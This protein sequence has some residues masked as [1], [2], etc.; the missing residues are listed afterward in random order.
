MN[1]YE[2]LASLRSLGIEIWVEGQQLH[3][4]A[5][6]GVLTPA[7]RKEM[8]DRKPEILTVLHSVECS[9]QASPFGIGET[10]GERPLTLSSGQQRLWFMAQLNPFSSAYNIPFARRIKMKIV[11]E[12]LELCISEVIRRHEVLRTTFQSFEGQP[13]P[14]IHP[15]D[16][17]HL[18][19]ID[20][21]DLPVEEQEEE[22]RRLI[23]E[24]SLLPFD[25]CQGP[26]IRFSLIHL[27]PE[28]N[29]IH[30]VVHHIIFDGW[31]IEILA[32][33]IS[34]FYRSLLNNQ[35]AHLPELRHQYTDFAAWQQQQLS[36][37]ALKSQLRYWKK[38]LD[39]S[40][41][42]LELPTDRTVL[43]SKSLRGA[44]E[45][46]VLSEKLSLA[47]VT[48]AHCE[49]V[50]LFMVILA[51]FVTLLHRITGQEDIILG[52]P[53]AGRN[54]PKMEGLIGLF[55][56]TLVLRFDVSG[57]PTF[58]E[59]L[60]AVRETA[61]EA[62]SNQDVPFER[63]VEELQPERNLNHNPIFDV[64]VNFVAQVLPP[65]SGLPEL[66]YAVD[67][68]ES[69]AKFPMTLYIEHRKECF[70]LRLTYQKEIFSS[71]RIIILLDQ[72]AKLLEQ[73]VAD[74]KRKIRSFSL[75]S[76]RS[77]HLLPDPTAPLSTPNYP[78]I[79]E[80]ITTW[81]ERIP[82][83]PAV[84]YKDK[85]WTYFD[86]LSRARSIA[87]YLINTG[88]QLGDVIAVYGSKSFG[89]Y[90]CMLGVFI[91]RGTLLCIAP[92]LPSRR[93][94][95]MLKTAH[96]SR[97]L[98]SGQQ[99]PS[100]AVEDLSNIHI[101]Q[102]QSGFIQGQDVDLPEPTITF[103]EVK[104]E[105]PAYIFFTSGTTNIPKAVLGNH[106]GLSHFLSWQRERFSIKPGDRSAQLTGLSFDVVLRDI[107]LPL[108][109]GATLCIPPGDEY[110]EPDQALSWMAAEEISILH[111]VPALAQ[112][113]LSDFTSDVILDNLRW[114]FFAGEPLSDALVK[115]F[116]EILSPQCGIINL[117]GPTETTLAKFYYSVPAEP[118]IG[119]Q[120]IGAPLPQ[121]QGLIISNTGIL[122]GIGEPGEIV[123]RTPFRSNGYIDN[124]QEQ[125]LRFA[126]NPYREDNQ[127]LVYHSGDLG[128]YRP[129]GGIDILGRLDD[130]IKIHG[131]RID[132]A[133][134]T[135]VLLEHPAMK[136]VFT[137][138]IQNPAGD[139]SLTAY[140]VLSKDSRETATSLR[141]FCAEQLPFAM[142]PS[143]FV[144]LD[145]LPLN[146][147]GKIDRDALPLP[148]LQTADE[149]ISPPRDDIE[150][151]MIKIW[152][153][154]LKIDQ[155]GISD[156]FFALGGYSLL[157][158]RLF[159]QIRKKFGVNLPLNSLFKNPTIDYLASLIRDQVDLAPWSSLVPI[160]PLGNHT[161]LY[162][163][164]GLTGDTVWFEY[165]K[166][167][168]D[169]DQPIWGL[170]SRGL[171]GVQEPLTTIEDMA[172][173]YID[174]IRKLQ[175]EGP[176]SLCGYSYGGTIVFEMARLLKQTG[177]RVSVLIIIDHATPKSNYYTVKFSLNLMINI[178]RNIPYRA[179][180]FLRLRPEQITA[181]LSRKVRNFVSHLK[182]SLAQ[183]SGESYGL[184]ATDLIDEAG[185]FSEHV[186]R[187]IE[188]NYN[189][190]FIFNPLAYDGKVTL[191]RS[192]GGRL[193][194][195]HDPAMGWGQFARGGVDIHIIP[196][197]HL[198]IFK[199]PYT[200]YLASEIEACILAAQNEGNNRLG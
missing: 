119:V 121:T 166:P 83:S 128:R 174:E 155:V 71:E 77:E 157:A 33:E 181:R 109:S 61:L 159:V 52:S 160:Q 45:V 131:V 102:A 163:V 150:N 62:Y 24:D 63:L 138:V 3:A 111:T 199:E 23:N 86:L 60:A 127:D 156:D 46:L 108:V 19:I 79:V 47:L 50:T 184:K 130:Q 38:K 6:K 198:S 44:N 117:Y 98:C 13:I 91:C 73:M 188:T 31:S 43:S 129:D 104:P 88:S 58:L 151:Q 134:I 189:A 149:E 27:S 68:P 187:I 55:L 118:F 76:P 1:I 144:F 186:R 22:V 57:D 116:R 28:D 106:R 103:P 90:A 179:V 9:E 51:G 94:R 137:T 124:Q 40:L 84:C 70:I 11:P 30:I 93:Q 85:T 171:D 7:I 147:N 34:E 65:S 153:K 56:N 123:I 105:D 29:I 39:G 10:S 197:S 183:K 133:E 126:T 8:E 136:A 78:S 200:H 176:Y 115:R 182:R 192:R 74:P 81:A 5:P 59:L 48:F 36:S 177:Q 32:R 168:M 193:L 165:L 164:H 154:L 42:R 113:W 140:V 195:N 17:F 15:P 196:G 66:G 143:T 112:S 16:P 4:S 185:Q 158:V 75:A 145:H 67:I 2:F 114:I 20:I 96:T 82:D 161:P 89:L 122:G 35:P 169:G 132:P 152:Q 100:E 80:S 54:Q 148:A 194:C 173:W 53:I 180:D 14:I 41:P 92:N 135:G 69:E 170:Q 178:L 101:I 25:L 120:P 190:I 87:N 95:M 12:V 162:C 141:Q 18:K 191:I 175:P 139:K 142:V 146:A 107:F 97:I 125:A 172:A 21:Q 37:E 72:L 167:Y 64:L 49:N 99:I 110:G 26:L